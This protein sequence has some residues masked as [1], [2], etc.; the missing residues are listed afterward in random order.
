MKPTSGTGTIYADGQTSQSPASQDPR[1][2][3]L[4]THS[5]R[6][7]TSKD[8]G[9]GLDRII[10][11][12]ASRSSARDPGPPP[13]GGFEAWTQALTAHLTVAVTWGYIQTFG[14][15]WQLFLAQGICTGLGNGL[16][17]CPALSLL[18]TYFNSKRAL[19]IGIG[20]SGSATGGLI[21]PAI[22]QQLLSKI[23]FGW[24]VRVLGFILLGLQ[25]IAFVFTKPRLPP[26]KTG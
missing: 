8:S 7:E 25:T 2:D 17:F 22:V 10:S 9:A 3:R 15:Y 13:D 12:I 6:L 18:S 11:R 16:I 24:A 20:A 14:V 26:R 1:S 5:E 21:F 19:A 4:N 23:G